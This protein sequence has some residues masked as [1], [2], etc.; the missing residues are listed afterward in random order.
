MIKVIT[1]DLDGVYFP[2]GK[3]N[4]IKNLANWGVSES[5]AKRVF[6]ESAEMNQKYKTG[7]W[8]DEQFWAWARAEWKLQQGPAEIVNL[9]I[10]GYSVDENVRQT[11]KAVRAAGYKTAICSNNFPA[12]I[13]GLQKRF[14]F[15]DDFDVVVWAY[16]V[17]VLKPD[18]KIFQELIKK[19]D[20]QPSEIFYT[21]DYPAALDAAKALGIQTHFYTNFQDFMAALNQVGVKIAS[22]GR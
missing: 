20:V 1:F 14:G 9:L 3:A 15:L 11:V 5:E 21:D 22:A 2:D 6:L 16:Q 12:R 7:Q 4:F 8:T 17:G 13:Q 19:S 10:S 18:P